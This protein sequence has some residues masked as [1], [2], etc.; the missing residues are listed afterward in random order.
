MEPMTILA[1]ASLLATGAGAVQNN[2]AQKKDANARSAVL[3]AERQRQKEFGDA[4]AARLV[5]TTKQLSPEEQAAETNAAAD[6]R[7]IATT[8][9]STGDYSQVTSGSGEKPVEVNSEIARA[10]VGALRKGTQSAVA[11]SRLSAYGD[12]NAD[13]NIRMLRSGSDIGRIANASAGSANVVPNELYGANMAGNAARDRASLY[14]ALG[15]IGMS[16]AMTRPNTPAT[17]KPTTSQYSLA[18]SP[19]S[20]SVSGLTY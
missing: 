15:Q 18:R 19:T 1:I 2:K 16:Y 5:E 9:Q 17:V 4:A 10:L 12:V 3:A 20:S 13:N 11:Q 8:P 14:N 7:A 6:T